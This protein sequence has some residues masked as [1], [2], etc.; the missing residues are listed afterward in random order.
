MWMYI[1]AK[2]E[3]GR[4]AVP[5]DGWVTEKK[6]INIEFGYCCSYQHIQSSAFYLAKRLRNRQ[7]TGGR[8]ILKNSLLHRTVRP[9]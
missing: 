7:K 8:I 3:M 6:V 5:E 4:Y 2:P 9:R 1:F